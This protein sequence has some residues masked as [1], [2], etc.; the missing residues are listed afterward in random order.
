MKVSL[1]CPEC[2]RLKEEL[3]TFMA[4]LRFKN[5]CTYEL[6]CPNGHE[7]K[8]NI[9]YHEF[10]KL[11]EIGVTSLADEYYREA[12]CAFAASYERFMELFVRVALRSH[13]V[14][15]SL[16]VLIWKKVA[17][18]SE[19]QLGA[20]LLLYSLEFKAEPQTLPDD[21]VNLRNKTIHQGYFPTKEESIKYGKEVLGRIREAIS[22][23]YASDRHRDAFIRSINDQGDFS[24]SGLWMTFYAYSLIGTN[25]PPEQ[26][27]K[28]F[29]E[30]LEDASKA[31][32]TAQG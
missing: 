26:D 23:L 25:R 1:S 20:F 32:A 11:F 22:R 29:K 14:D 15:A 4:E 17:R 12:V 31:R 8:A 13:S 5:D 6:K 18:Q 10:Q 27:T 30:M 28:S 21:L 2:M 24:D 7:F 9:L 19:R 16:E 3:L